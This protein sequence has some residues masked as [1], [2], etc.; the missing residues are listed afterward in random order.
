MTL[1]E[2]RGTV[3]H[4]DW[5]EGNDFDTHGNGFWFSAARCLALLIS[6][7]IFANARSYG[8]WLSST[9]EVTH[10][11]R[12][13]LCE[14]VQITLTGLEQLLPFLPQRKVDFTSR[15]C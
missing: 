1:Q 14:E 7:L 8:T 12:V 6:L 4:R 11:P 2:A 3:A 9:C 5:V 13:L 15:T 10:S